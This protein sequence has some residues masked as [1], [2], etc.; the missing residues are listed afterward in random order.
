MFVGLCGTSN[1]RTQN[2]TI[3]L[4]SISRSS[5]I[6][7]HYMIIDDKESLVFPGKRF[8]NT[9]TRFC[10]TLLTISNCA[11][12]LGFI[13]THTHMLDCEFGDKCLVLIMG[14]VSNDD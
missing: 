14:Q 3:Y 11:T 8:G 2:N 13:H 10:W 1:D 5:Y 9:E 12:S 4:I 7:Q 6:V